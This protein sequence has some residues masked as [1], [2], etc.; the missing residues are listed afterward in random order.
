MEQQVLAVV[1]GIAGGDL[2][3]DTPLAAVG[4]DSLAAVELRNELCR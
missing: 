1:Q 4:V 3:P 2:R